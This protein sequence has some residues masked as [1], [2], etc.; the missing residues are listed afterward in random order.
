MS[1]KTQRAL[2]KRAAMP[3]CDLLRLMVAL[4]RLSCEATG[5]FVVQGVGPLDSCFLADFLNSAV[6]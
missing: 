5:V 2:T 6:L 3:T 4:E 1:D